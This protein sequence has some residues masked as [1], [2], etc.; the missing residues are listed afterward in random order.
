MS[1]QASRPT[2]SHC[3]PGQNMDN[4]ATASPGKEDVQ[5]C[6]GAVGGILVFFVYCSLT[7]LEIVLD[8][9]F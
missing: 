1:V 7:F 2:T 5:Q 8:L 4:K 3:G 6:H 9:L